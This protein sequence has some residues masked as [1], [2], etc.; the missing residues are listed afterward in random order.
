ML[1][2]YNVPLLLFSAG[3]GDVIEEVIRQQLKITDNM[4]IVSN[5]MEFNGNVCI[6]FQNSTVVLN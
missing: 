2:K 6:V 5:Y 4:R 1:H 3:I